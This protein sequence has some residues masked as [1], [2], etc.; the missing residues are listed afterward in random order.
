MAREDY[1]LT[2]EA[3][4]NHFPAPL[5]KKMERRPRQEYQVENAS[6]KKRPRKESGLDT[7]AAPAAPIP[8]HVEQGPLQADEL[9]GSGQQLHL[10][11]VAS[12]RWA[13]AS[14][15]TTTTPADPSACSGENSGGLVHARLKTRKKKPTAEVEIRPA[16]VKSTLIE[17]ASGGAPLSVRNLYETVRGKLGKT[18]IEMPS[19][20][21][22]VVM[23]EICGT[24]QVEF[25]ML[26]N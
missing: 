19:A 2:C 21:L 4:D 24:D 13:E 25:L 5:Q 17:I 22:R 23:Q 12:P 9:S 8:G 16:Q 26:K 1:E 15:E 7:A 18:T 6:N 10:Q 14:P 11:S 3:L 20:R